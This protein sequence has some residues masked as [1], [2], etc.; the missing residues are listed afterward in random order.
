M[1]PRRRLATVLW[2]NGALE[3]FKANFRQFHQVVDGSGS[4]AE[5]EWLNLRRVTEVFRPR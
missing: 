3:R 1:K 2:V 5:K 4:E